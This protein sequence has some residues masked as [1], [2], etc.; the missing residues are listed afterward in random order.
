MT[1]QY[2]H[3][4]QILK[5][6]GD[7]DSQ[8][9]GV[10]AELFSSVRADRAE[11]SELP[12]SDLAN[13]EEVLSGV[14]SHGHEKLTDLPGEENVEN[15]SSVDKLLT[16]NKAKSLFKS[17]FVYAI[18]FAIAFGV[19]FL[20]LNFGAV[21]KQ[22]Q[23][24]FIKAEPQEVL[25]AETQ[26]YY[27]WI[28]GYYFSVSD[29]DKLDPQN[30][31]DF[32]GLTNHDEYILKTNPLIADG[33][34]D[35]YKDGLEVIN[36]YN[37]WGQ[38]KMSDEQKELVKN[39][40]MI[41]VNNRISY[42][43]A[44]SN[45]FK[46]INNQSVPSSVASTT[47]NSRSTSGSILGTSQLNSSQ[48]TANGKL[49]IPKLKIQVPIIWST[50]PKNFDKDLTKGV[51]HYPGTAMPGENG[52][53][54]ITGHS[55]DYIWKKH[56]YMQ[57]FAQLNRLEP[58]DDIFI[59]VPQSDGSIKAYRYQVTASKI[60]GPTDQEQFI[61]EYSEKLNLSTCWPIGTSKDRLVVS[62]VPVQL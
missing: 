24:L 25:G 23:G 7:F 37:P 6:S 55:S 22:I 14:V 40:D 42:N 39:I 16:N 27:E 36:D 12:V 60:Y 53:I 44:S 32:D 26:S 8:F 33:D 61:G 15:A 13:T 34:E 9:P 56:P 4:N 50:D 29:V 47:S 49:S 30:D 43:S 45:N 5:L 31:I 28:Q 18:V 41:L 19:F 20:I 59:E 10:P 46:P 35:G 38:G 17:I 21:V 3:I 11:H 54:Y 1:E 52:I 58:G 62:A 2:N 51:I 48:S 57:I